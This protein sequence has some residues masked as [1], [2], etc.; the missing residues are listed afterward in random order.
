MF[1]LDGAKSQAISGINQ[2][3]NNSEL[4][5]LSLHCLLSCIPGTGRDRKGRRMRQLLLSSFS[6]RPR[7][8]VPN[9]RDIFSIILLFPISRRVVAAALLVNVFVVV[10]DE[11]LG[12]LLD[13]D[14]DEAELTTD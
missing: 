13:C 11:C 1:K 12:H 4:A 2:Q 5:C 7:P 9:M 10:G 8:S 6:V 3:Q 14:C